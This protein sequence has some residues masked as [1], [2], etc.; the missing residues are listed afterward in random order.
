[1]L[2]LR[3]FEELTNTEVAHTLEIQEAAA[4]KRYVRALRRLKEAL[5]CHAR[6]QRGVSTVNTADG[7]T[8]RDPFDR[9]AESFLERFRRGER[10]SISEYIK[11]NPDHA[12]DI[13]ELFPALVEVEQLK[14]AGASDS[15]FRGGKRPPLSR[16]G[17]YQILG[18]VGEGGMGIVYEAIRESLRSRVAL[19]IMHPR[20]RENAGYLRRFHVEACA[21][22]SLH[23]TNIVSVFDYGETDGVVYY[24]MPYIAGQ[25]LEKVLQD[26]KRIRGEQSGDPR[27]DP[28]SDRTAADRRRR[29]TLDLASPL[30]VG[31][32]T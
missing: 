20:F 30:D 9:L 27:R 1:M 21:A 14:S 5:S 10:P 22:A 3:H 13:Q 11:N 6:R 32:E 12:S 7:G 2:I 15:I 18:I 24:A 16:L 17:D 4:S 29:D 8:T 26:V 31:R 25:S 19:K 23:H 28:Q